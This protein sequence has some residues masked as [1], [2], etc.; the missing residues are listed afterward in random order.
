[1]DLSTFHHQGVSGQYMYDLLTYWRSLGYSQ[2]EGEIVNRCLSGSSTS[3]LFHKVS[4]IP[5]P[6]FRD[7]GHLLVNNFEHYEEVPAWQEVC[8]LRGRIDA[9]KSSTASIPEDIKTLFTCVAHVLP[10]RLAQRCV[11]EYSPPRGRRADRGN[12]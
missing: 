4:S 10:M 1:M 5:A 3:E 12:S 7:V 9:G 2:E 11:R 6:T 8:L